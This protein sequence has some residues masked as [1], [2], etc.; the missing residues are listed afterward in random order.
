MI[1]G[2]VTAILLVV[3]LAIAAWAWSARN[4]ERFD[5]AARLPLADETTPPQARGCGDCGCRGARP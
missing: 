2:I 5:A 4:R 1:G 3:F